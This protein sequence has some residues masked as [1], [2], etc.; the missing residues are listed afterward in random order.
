MA[1]T[2]TR[3]GGYFLDPFLQQ[4][5][6][7]GVKTTWANINYYLTTKTAAEAN[8]C[9][10]GGEWPGVCVCV[11]PQGLLKPLHA[12]R[13]Q[14]MMFLGLQELLHV[15]QQDVTGRKQ[16]GT[17]PQQLPALLLTVPA[18][19]T[20]GWRFLWDDSR[21]SWEGRKCVTGTGCR[22]LLWFLE[23]LLCAHTWH[24]SPWA[25]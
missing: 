23:E 4:T 20:K 1:S 15:R 11:L 7:G 21:R 24:G 10:G 3:W 9:G 17:E 13:S 5:E 18:H 12:V 19:R 14:R 2:S 16:T 6:I 8:T 22:Y 25:V